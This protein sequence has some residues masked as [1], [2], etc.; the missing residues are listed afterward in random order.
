MVLVDDGETHVVS[1]IPEEVV[2]QTL[3]HFGFS[4]H[5]LRKHCTGEG[6]CERTG[7]NNWKYEKQ[8]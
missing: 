4:K 8:F 5:A 7:R 6:K 3:S 2:W 1:Y